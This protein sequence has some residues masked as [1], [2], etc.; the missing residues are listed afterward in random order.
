MAEEVVF[1]QLDDGVQKGKSTYKQLPVRL[2][3]KEELLLPSRSTIPSFPALLS[4]LLNG[5]TWALPS[6]VVYERN[7]IL[8][9]QRSFYPYQQSYLPKSLGTGLN[10]FPTFFQTEG[11]YGLLNASTAAAVGFCA[12]TIV[13]TASSAIQARL[14]PGPFNP[15]DF[16]TKVVTNLLAAA[17]TTIML[18]INVWALKARHHLMST[19]IYDTSVFSKGMLFPALKEAF[20]RN[21]Y[22]SSLI[23]FYARL[24]KRPFTWIHNLVVLKA[25]ASTPTN[26]LAIRSHRVKKLYQAS[27]LLAEEA[28][29][30]LLTAPIHTI[31]LRLLAY[32]YWT[33]SAPNE[34]TGVLGLHAYFDCIKRTY[35]APDGGGL[36]AFYEGFGWYLLINALYPALCNAIFGMPLAPGLDLP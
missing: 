35:N 11:A 24:L 12:D 21:A 6:K 15:N 7:H 30:A 28:T 4:P 19:G 29:M 1:I 27:I 31:Y 10:A 5:L 22:E 14:R 13:N 36:L 18:P 25:D 33:A 2:E 32:E 8:A 17:A 16:M 9:A 34:G 20:V 26:D 23:E 3:E